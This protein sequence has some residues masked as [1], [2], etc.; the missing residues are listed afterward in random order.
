MKEH[1]NLSILRSVTADDDTPGYE[2]SICCGN[3]N[4]K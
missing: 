1:L 4:Q 2:V 3:S